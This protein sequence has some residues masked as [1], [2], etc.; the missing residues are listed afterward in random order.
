MK[1]IL[2]RQFSIFLLLFVTVQSNA[3]IRAGAAFLKMLPGARVQSMS[4]AQT[5]IIDDVHSLYANPGSAGFLREWQWS[6]SYTKWIAD[7][8]N[9]SFLYGK[10]VHTPWSRRTNLAVGFLYQ[11]V[12][13][14]DST[15]DTMP[16]ASSNDMVASLSIGQPLT[17]LTDYIS[18]GANFKYLRSKLADFSA[19]APVADF[20]LLI[21]TPRFGM[22]NS[23]FPYGIVT[24]GAALTQYGG[25]INFDQQG[26]PLP[27]TRRAGLAFYTGSHTGLQF[28]VTADYIDVMDEDNYIAMGTEFSIGRTFSINAGYDFGGDLMEKVTFGASIRLD[29]INFP[30]GEVVPGRNNALRFDVASVNEADFFSRTYRGTATHYPIRPEQFSFI[31]ATENDTFYTDTVRVHWQP[32]KDPDLYDD[33]SYTLVMDQNYSKMTRLAYL[34]NEDQGNILEEIKNTSYM[35]K[36]NLKDTEYLFNDIVGGYYYWMVVAIDKDKHIRLAKKGDTYISKFYVPLPDIQIDQIVF[37][38]SPWITMDDYHGDIRVHLSNRGDRTASQF[39]VNIS[40]SVGILKESLDMDNV[41]QPTTQLISRAVI[42]SLLPGEEKVIPLQWNTKWLGKH[43]FI[44]EADVDSNLIE[45]EKDKNYKVTSFYTI[46]KGYLTTADTALTILNSRVEINTPIVTVVTFDTNKTDVSM[47][48]LTMS[49]FDPHLSIIAERLVRKPDQRITLKGWADPNSENATI[50]LANRRSEAVRDTLISRRVRPEQI[51]ILPGEVWES[52]RTPSN[53]DDRRWIFEERRMVKIDSD[54]LGQEE[55]FEPVYIRD[56]EPLLKNIVFDTQLKY[57]V[58]AEESYAAYFGKG[59]VDTLELDLKEGA[60]IKTHIEWM[61]I[62][63]GRVYWN[64]KEAEYQLKVVDNLGRHFKTRPD[65][66]VMK[67]IDVLRENRMAI[68]LQF[69]NTSPLYEFY[70]NLLLEQMSSILENPDMRIA[71]SGHACATGSAQINEALSDRR[72][73]TF[74]QEFMEYMKKNAPDNYESIMSR[75]DPP[76][77]YGEYNPLQ[78]ERLTGEQILIGNNEKSSGRILNR[79]IEIKIYLTKSPLDAYK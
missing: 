21:R 59:I 57:A 65:T 52:R 34:Y 1:K 66:V 76:R 18:L 14:F 25:T 55:L 31:T 3:Q 69:N 61:P 23:V 72:V 75:V 29:D 67:A 64:E 63:Y 71:F 24:M 30:G 68:P 58:P 50:D 33:V 7:I 78:V 8:S 51:R 35:V 17:F 54:T 16:Y 79:R 26:T 4:M 5:G 44:V 13:E 11:G 19:G 74:Q 62:P 48:Y 46:P 38:Y 40:D 27:E 56:D 60:K 2:I 20:G 70:L 10:R 37:N 22:G 49:Q 47:D 77:G 6:A 39:T 45:W 28:V 42:D 12:P 32:S 73:K 43:E 53:P 15:D 9:A 41:N 36:T